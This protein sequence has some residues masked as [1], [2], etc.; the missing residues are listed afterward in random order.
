VVNGPAL[1]E[2]HEST[3]VITGGTSVT[4]DAHYNLIAELSA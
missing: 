4:V 2:E 3:C 1:I